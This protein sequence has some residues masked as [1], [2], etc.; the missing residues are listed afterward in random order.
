MRGRADQCRCR[1]C[2]NLG[3]LSRHNR[4]KALANRKPK[5][6]RFDTGTSDLRGTVLFYPEKPLSSEEEE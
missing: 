4:W 6:D 5:S 1:C 2:Q 3:R